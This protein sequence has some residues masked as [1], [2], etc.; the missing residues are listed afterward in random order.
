MV[1]GQG[2]GVPNLWR[3]WVR[4]GLVWMKGLDWRSQEDLLTAGADGLESLGR[5]TCLFFADSL[6]LGVMVLAWLQI[7]SEHLLTGDAPARSGS[8]GEEPTRPT[9]SFQGPRASLT[10]R[11]SCPSQDALASSLLSPPTWGSSLLV[12]AWFGRDPVPINPTPRER[13]RNIC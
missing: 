3:S 9:A 4:A 13:R 1:E 10:E 5:E 6:L 11:Q 12:P 8:L 2:S 7:S